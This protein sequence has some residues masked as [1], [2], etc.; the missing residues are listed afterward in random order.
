MKVLSSNILHFKQPNVEDFIEH[1]KK[2]TSVHELFHSTL[3]SHSQTFSEFISQTEVPIEGLITDEEM[4]ADLLTFLKDSKTT[5]K[6]S[7]SEPTS[8][9]KPKMDETDAEKIKEKVL[10]HSIMLQSEMKALNYAI[11]TLSEETKKHVEKL[12]QE[13]EQ[14]REEFESKIS[15]TRTEFE[16]KKGEL[17]KQRDE[18]MEK[19]SVT[20]EKEVDAKI[21]EKKKWEQELLRLE[22][23]KSEYEKRK[24]LRKRKN[25]QVGEARWSTRLRDAE[26]KISTVKGK[27][28]TLSDFI[29]RS[30]KEAEKATKKVQNR[31]QKLLDEERMKIVNLERSRDQDLEKKEKEITEIQ[32]ESLVITDKIERLIDQK[33]ERT[34]A[35]KEHTTAWKVNGNTLIYVPFYLIQYKTEKEKRHVFRSPT[36]ARGHEGLVMKI[37]KT[38]GRYNTLLKARSKALEKLLASFEENLESDKKTQNDLENLG[39]SHNLIS[40]AGFK[41]SIKKG[42]DELEV[43]GWIKLEEKQTIIKT[44]TQD[45]QN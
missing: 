13:M 19:I 41:E 30:N 23:N 32:Q 40:S 10:G 27:I 15:S 7:M 39:M 20:L 37:R 2:S 33:R 11:D 38:F 42:L 22:Q 1:L 45:G 8:S 16:K 21:S 12:R 24:E 29:K 25:D 6:R 44:Y 9:I 4:L 18:K 26:N 35:L 43:E 31:C 5:I 17:E 28:K 36:I 34:V 14:T 3:R